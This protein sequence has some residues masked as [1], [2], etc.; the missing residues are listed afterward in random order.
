V[1]YLLFRNIRCPPNTLENFSKV[2]TEGGP[3]GAPYSHSERVSPYYIYIY[4][5][6]Y[7]FSLGILGGNKRKKKR[8]KKKKKGNDPSFGEEKVY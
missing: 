8:R 6:I 3:R 5:Y 2:L 4:I 1:A 7:H